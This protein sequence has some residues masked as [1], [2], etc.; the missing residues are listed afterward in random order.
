MNSVVVTS[1]LIRLSVPTHTRIRTLAHRAD[2]IA[3]III[4]KVVGVAYVA[5]YSAVVVCATLYPPIAMY[6]AAVGADT[7]LLS[8]GG[9]LWIMTLLSYVHCSVT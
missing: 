9:K 1:E 7:P 3:L 8:T 2:I 4:I 5:Y 6:V